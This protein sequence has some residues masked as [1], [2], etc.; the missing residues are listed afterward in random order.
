MKILISEN[1]VEIIRAL[2]KRE[3]VKY[4]ANIVGGFEHL[5]KILGHDNVPEY[6]YQYLTE[7]SYPDYNWYSHDDYKQVVK[8]YGSTEFY[9]NDR[10]TFVYTEYENGYKKLEVYPWLYNEME[11]LFSINEDDTGWVKII[12]NWF[13]NN[14]GLKVDMVE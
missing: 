3:G 13:E 14:T 11:D 7:N 6:I 9:V 8:D 1:K 10:L 2:I 5:A 4:A 12:A